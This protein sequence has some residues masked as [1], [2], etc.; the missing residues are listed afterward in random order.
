MA[1][2][3]PKEHVLG[4]LS[5]IALTIAALMVLYLDVSFGVKMTILLVTAGLQ[6]SL[7]L[8]LFMHIGESKEKGTLYTNILY[9][10]FV[11]IVTIFG[12]LFVLVW[13]W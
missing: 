8:F 2:L 4:F 11:A 10:L 7:Q 12:S 13:D 1:K 6:A 3:F 9:A 5:S